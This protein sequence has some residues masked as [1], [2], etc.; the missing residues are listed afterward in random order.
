MQQCLFFC[1]DTLHC[2]A[3]PTD[4]FGSWGRQRRE[5]SAGFVLQALLG[6]KGVCFLFLE[7]LL[8]A[9]STPAPSSFAWQ[10]FLLWVVSSPSSAGPGET[11]L[12]NPSSLPEAPGFVCLAPVLGCLSRVPSPAGRCLGLGWVGVAQGLSGGQI[13]IGKLQDFFMKPCLTSRGQLEVMG[14][15]CLQ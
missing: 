13:A 3:L 14:S 4:H 1:A 7:A 9:V 15:G 12:F 5:P 8:A 2:P 10:S 6:P 11:L